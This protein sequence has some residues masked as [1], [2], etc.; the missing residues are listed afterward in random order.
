MNL[1]TLFAFWA[2]TLVN[3]EAL[4]NSTNFMRNY[5][6]YNVSVLRT[7]NYLDL[8][9]RQYADHI[10]AFE[11]EIDV[12][13]KQ[14]SERLSS[15][16]LVL[17]MLVTDIIKTNEHLNPLE[18]LSDISKD[19]VAKYRSK[20]PT[21]A[22]TKTAVQA[23]ITAA[24]NQ[25]NNI[26]SAAT[27]TKTNLYNYYQNNMEKDFKGC[28]TKHPAQDNSYTECIAK[29]ISAVTAYT[30]VMLKQFHNQM[31]TA[32]CSANSNIKTALDCS[33]TVQNRTITMNAEANLMINRCIHGLDDC[34]RC[35]QGRFCENVYYLPQYQVDYHNSTMLNPF[36]G[37]N[38]T[39]HCLLIDVYRKNMAQ[40]KM[41]IFLAIVFIANVQRS[42]AVNHYAARNSSVIRN[43][44]YIEIVRH[45]NNFHLWYNTLRINTFSDTY[46]ARINDIE[47]HKQSLLNVVERANEKL[48]PWIVLNDVS[49]D[50]VEKYNKLIPSLAAASSEMEKCMVN[51]LAWTNNLIQTM[52]ATNRSLDTYYTGTFEKGVTNCRTKFNSSFPE[53]YTRCLADVVSASN[54]YTA[55]SQDTFSN[56]LQT[57]LGSAEYYIKIAHECSFRVANTS[58][59]NIQRANDLIDHCLNGW[60]ENSKCIAKGFYCEQVQRMPNY[61]I[62][63]SNRTMPNPFYGQKETGNCLMLDIVDE[64]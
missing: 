41:L 46:K 32:H 36:Y 50:C 3:I 57:A 2:C 59:S 63:R 54:I 21:V 29:V 51:G 9:R 27:T 35:S 42:S 23:C 34:E 18:V 30:R 5:L 20:V 7:E 40:I 25:L 11:K 12:F 4:N 16:Q 44:E 19:C 37:R 24:Q 56:Q 22:A 13:R 52:V 39:T 53:N 38:S 60:D 49:K 15:I 45:Q 47:F 26:V 8:N 62:D 14:F 28:T 64:N 55:S 33:Y 58:V 1:K 6:N 31:D 43:D 48:D 61:L 17:D 10:L